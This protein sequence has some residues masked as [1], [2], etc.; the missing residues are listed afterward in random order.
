[1]AKTVPS[2]LYGTGIYLSIFMYS[3]RSVATALSLLYLAHKY[4]VPD[5]VLPVL[6]YLILNTSDDYVLPV[7]QA[8]LLY[9]R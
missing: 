3:C 5:L 1:M 2:A 4:M 7:L 9:Y 6:Q 8:V